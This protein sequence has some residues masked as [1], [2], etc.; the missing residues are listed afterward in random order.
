MDWSTFRLTTTR[1]L[2]QTLWIRLAIARKSLMFQKPFTVAPAL[3]ARVLP[4]AFITFAGFPTAE[5]KQCS[6][7]M[8][9]HPQGHWSYR[10]IDGRKCWYQGENNFPKSSLQWSGRAAALSAFGKAEKT[11]ERALPPSAATRPIAENR[12]DKSGGD[13]CCKDSESFEA[14]WRGLEAPR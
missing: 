12:N 8:P 11:P 4:I 13:G 7:A 9:S 1:F 14:R 10:L 6:V 3:L 5:A 2:E